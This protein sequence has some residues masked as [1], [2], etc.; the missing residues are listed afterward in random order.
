MLDTLDSP[1]VIIHAIDEL[2]SNFN[3]SQSDILKARNRKPTETGGLAVKL[4]LKLESRVMLTV[5]IDIVDRLINGQMGI[6]KHFQRNEHNR[7]VTIYVKFDDSTAGKK[8][9]S[10]YNLAKHNNWVPIT[11]TDTQIK[12]RERSINSPTIQRTQFP[13][14][15][16]WAC[17]VHKV[18]GL[19]LQTAVISFNLHKQ[20]ASNAGQMYV[21]LS[22]L[23]NMDGLFLTGNYSRET[24]RVNTHAN[25]EY[26][27]INHDAPFIPLEKVSTSDNC[28]VFGLFNTRSLKKHAIDIASDQTMYMM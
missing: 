24:I 9:S 19:S 20:K 22:R 14:I 26:E 15:L 28:L 16:S 18:Q 7:V 4:S 3:V 1:L 23:T 21:A 5:N 17:T 27:R 12:I 8:T 6:V 2:P 11:A 10:T 25:E 13:L